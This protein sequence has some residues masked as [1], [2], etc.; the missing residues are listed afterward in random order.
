MEEGIFCPSL[1][2]FTLTAKFIYSVAEAFLCWYQNLF[3]IPTQTEED[4]PRYPDSW[5]EQLADLWPFHQKTAIVELAGCQPVSRSNTAVCVH[6]HVYICNFLILSVLILENS[7]A[8][9]QLHFYVLIQHTHND[10][11]ERRG[12]NFISSFMPFC[13][14]FILP[15]HFNTFCFKSEKSLWLVLNLAFQKPSS[16]Q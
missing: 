16:S 14:Y 6:I 8:Y 3:G 10:R 12:G 5:T 11:V 4:Q 7:N 2:T 9:F 13:I 15:L 1:L